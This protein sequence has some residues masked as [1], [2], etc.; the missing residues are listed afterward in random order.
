MPDKKNDYLNQYDPKILRLIKVN[1]NSITRGH[2]IEFLYQK[3]TR[4]HLVF[5]LTPKWMNKMHA[6]KLNEIP[7]R[8]FEHIL[9]RIRTTNPHMIR[10]SI[11]KMTAPVG[12]E[13]RKPKAF[14]RTY[15]K[16]TT[17]FTQ[18]EPYRTY[19]IKEMKDIMI[20]DYDFGNLYEVSDPPPKGSKLEKYRGAPRQ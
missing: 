10:E 9:K 4:P 11:A 7:V 2:I 6:V 16:D 13:I 19:S 17:V 14:Y 3:E 15:F 5:V 20:V 18:F 12:L 8:K 1:F